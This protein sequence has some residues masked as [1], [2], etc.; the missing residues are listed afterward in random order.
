MPF[1]LSR[2]DLLR[3]SLSAAA[4]C[5]ISAF[6]TRP[7]RGI[8]F[9]EPVPGSEYLTAYQNGPQVLLRWN[10][11]PLV[12]YRAHPTQKYPYFGPVSG[13]LSGLSL[14]TES[15]LPYPHHRGLWLGCDPLNGGDYWSDGPLA[16]GHIRSTA[17]V[18]GETNEGS[19]TFTDRCEWTREGA[20]SPWNDERRFTVSA[21][22]ERI[23]L[24]DAEITL[25]ALEDVAIQGA[26]HSFF[27]L[28]TAP[29]LAPMY[30]GTLLNS[31]GGE[32][33][34]GTYG[35]PARWCGYFGARA[36]LPDVVE[37]IAIMNHPDNPWSP[38][39]WFTRDY[40]HLSPSPFNFLDSPWRLEQGASIHLKYRVVSHAG[41][42]RQA[43][44]DKLFR[45]W[46]EG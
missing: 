6:D 38:L 32:S 28:R 13:P 29:D 19:A 12:I 30:G 24:I 15:A 41:D 34:E 37:G 46:V 8:D 20:G 7:A 10:N 11:A 21:P 1:Q 36:G 4:A 18:L 5:A 42:P 22:N 2:R 3:G 14:T 31:E 23:R 17:L 27:A 35:K 43:G 33:A 39:P 16:E 25:H 45:Q 26:K 9:T 40:G 44:M